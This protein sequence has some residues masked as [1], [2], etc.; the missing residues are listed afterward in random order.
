MFSSSRRLFLNQ[1]TQVEAERL[2]P[3]AEEKRQ[4]PL[5]SGKKNTPAFC[6]GVLEGRHRVTS[7]AVS[8]YELA[9]LAGLIPG[10]YASKLNP[11]Q[12]GMELK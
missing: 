9:Q 1:L 10:K 6:L 3:S 4:S 8:C 7:P 11:R 5:C 12:G 2:C